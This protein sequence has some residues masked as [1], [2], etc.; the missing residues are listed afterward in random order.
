MISH[1]E[2][3]RGFTLVETLVAISILVVAIVGP[4]TIAMRGLQSAFFAKEQLTAIYL[5]QE[6]VE[7]IRMH[8]DQYALVQRATSNDNWLSSPSRLTSFCA[9]ASGCGV[10]VNLLTNSGIRDCSVTDACR[11]RYRSSGVTSAS[12]GMYIHGGTFAFSPYTRVV[13][14]QDIGGGSN[15]DEVDVTVTVSWESSFFSGT[16][17]VTLQERLFSQYD[18]Y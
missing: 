11:L 9:T 12:R 7:I 15:S 17:S 3:Q 8:R 6:A 13:K 14:V 10:D 4:M 5:A 16:K 1:T 18:D 2:Q